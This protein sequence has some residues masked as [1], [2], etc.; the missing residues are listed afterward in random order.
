MVLMGAF[1]D[2]LQP[3][4]LRIYKW[5]SCEWQGFMTSDNTASSP[6]K[7][8][9]ELLTLEKVGDKRHAPTLQEESEAKGSTV[10]D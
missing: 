10:Q 5:A 4:L 2:S 6:S 8:R 7:S 1:P 3:A 9:Q